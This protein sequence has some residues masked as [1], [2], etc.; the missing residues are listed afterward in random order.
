MIRTLL[1]FAFLLGSISIGKLG[2][3]LIIGVFI[4]YFIRKN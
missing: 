4:I 3:F 2:I 1:T